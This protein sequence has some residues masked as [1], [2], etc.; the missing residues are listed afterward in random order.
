[1]KTQALKTNSVPL[2]TDD[3]EY[4]LTTWLIAVTSFRDIYYQLV[5]CVHEETI[6]RESKAGGR[7]YIGQCSVSELARLIRTMEEELKNL[8]RDIDQLAEPTLG[9]TSKNYKMLASHTRI[10]T[11]LNQKALNGLYLITQS[12][13]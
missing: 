6:G 9:N 7:A 10:L 1:M 2:D 12:S 11:Q 8:E 4:I 5:A 3:P 13:S